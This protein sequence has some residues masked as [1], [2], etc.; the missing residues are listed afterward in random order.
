M[1]ETQGLNWLVEALALRLHVAPTETRGWVKMVWGL[2]LSG[3]SSS[4]QGVWEG[5]VQGLTTWVSGLD[6]ISPG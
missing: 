3:G 1:G 5:E 4:T 2:P 6:S